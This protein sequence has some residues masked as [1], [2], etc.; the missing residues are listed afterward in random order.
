MKENVQMIVY[1]N[2]RD[3][4]TVKVDMTNEIE[5]VGS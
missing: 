5:E 3:H 2:N 4:E 1:V